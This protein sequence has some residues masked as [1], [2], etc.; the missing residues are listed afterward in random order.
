[1]HEILD[2]LTPQELGKRL[3]LVRQGLNLTQTEVA[4]E[5][6]TNQIKISKIEQGNSVTTPIFLRLIAFYAQS[7]SLDVLF[8]E[9]L[10]FVTF[11]NLFN[12]DFVKSKII[13]E[14]LKA[15]RIATAH[16]L[17]QAEDELSEAFDSAI[18]LL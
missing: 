10:D 13:K 9:K 16:S 15:V 5:I 11:E 18:A 17:K 14:K 6:G 8:S 7:I 12:Q 1:M 2:I 3:Q 4:R